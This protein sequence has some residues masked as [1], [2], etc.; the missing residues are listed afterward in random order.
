M[1]DFA[2][3]RRAR[4]Q[5][6]LNTLMEIDHPVRVIHVGGSASNVMVVDA[7]DGFYAPEVYLPVDR[8][9][10]ITAGGE[11]EMLHA[12]ESAGW[13][14][15]FG[16]SGQ[17]GGLRSAL[18]HP[19]EFVG[20]GVQDAILERPGVYVA[21]A[22]ECLLAFV[23]DEISSEDQDRVEAEPAGWVIAYKLDEN[24]DR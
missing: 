13:D 6:D 1:T 12:A 18:M 7:G 17:V 2:Y 16:L 22:V 4:T 10:Q 20:G 3:Y 21:C 11:A 15:M 14:L 24:T 23:D 9:G 5:P 19:S 8:D